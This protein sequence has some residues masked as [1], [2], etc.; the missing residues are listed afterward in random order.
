MNIFNVASARKF[1]VGDPSPVELGANQC[2]SCGYDCATEKI[3]KVMNGTFNQT[4]FFVHDSLFVCRRCLDVFKSKDS[5]TKILLYRDKG[6]KEILSREDV[7]PLLRDPPE[8]FVLCVP[9]SFQKHTFFFAGL[10]TSSHACI[11]TDN[12]MVELDYTRFDISR[13]IGTVQEM[14]LYGVPRK[15]LEMGRYSVFTRSKFGDYL[16]KNEKILNPLREFGAIELF[17]RY[18]PSV[19]NKKQFFYEEDNLFTDSEKNAISL[20]G[21]LADASGVRRNRPLDFW[22]GEFRRRVARY[23]EEKDLH[24]FFSKVAAQLQ[25]GCSLDV[26][27]ISQLDDASGLEAMKDIRNKLDILLAAVYTAHKEK[28]DIKQVTRK[29]KDQKNEHGSLSLFN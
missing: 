10:S 15:E 14:L 22:G 8:K 6:K 19:K 26:S 1:I 28:G 20:L 25:C 9:Y 12:R 29:N 16:E 24:I 7:L 18:S 2:V 13:V 11:G 17:C 21:A 23:Q 5:R 4:A 27:L 3:S